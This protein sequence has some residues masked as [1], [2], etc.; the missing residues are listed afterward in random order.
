M[1]GGVVAGITRVVS[2]NIGTKMMDRCSKMNQG[3]TLERR[4]R[5]APLCCLVMPVGEE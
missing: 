2:D 1:T 5:E 3:C 4:D